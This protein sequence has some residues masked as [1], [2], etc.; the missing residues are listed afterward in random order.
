[1]NNLIELETNIS[2]I[3][4]LKQ[5]DSLQIICD[6]SITP[7][8]ISL[9]NPINLNILFK[10][11]FSSIIY[12]YI[13][14]LIGDL[15]NSIE[16]LQV[17]FIEKEGRW[18]CEYGTIP[19]EK[20]LSNE[21][22]NIYL[23]KKYML[24]IGT[25][26]ISNNIKKISLNTIYLT[27]LLRIPFNSFIKAGLSEKMRFDLRRELFNKTKLM[28]PNNN[29]G[30]TPWIEIYFNS[31]IDLNNCIEKR[32]WCRVE[33]ILRKNE[34]TKEIFIYF[35]RICGDRTS[36]TYI[37]IS[38]KTCLNKIKEKDF[39]WIERSNFLKLYEGT[40]PLYQNYKEKYL[41]NELIIKELCSYIF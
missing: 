38:L 24:S 39:I 34:K 30:Q 19:F 9:S 4:I 36:A 12:K 17:K 28:F 25:H 1:M 10:V 5:Y 29:I 16:C 41:F 20:N 14:K 6:K 15:L 27:N 35:N 32:T 13:Y 26:I 8:L 33:I 11:K 18:L 31:N 21:E 37:N 7:Y 40:F 2:F 22:Y 23:H 3:N